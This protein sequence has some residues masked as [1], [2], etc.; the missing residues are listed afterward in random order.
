MLNL[1]SGD[2]S[3]EQ[4]VCRDLFEGAPPNDPSIPLV[5]L[6]HDQP[7]SFAYLPVGSEKVDESFH[8]A[9]RN[10]ARVQVEVEQHEIAGLSVLVASGDFYASEKI[11]DENSQRARSVQRWR[12]PRW[13][14]RD[15]A[16]S[17]TPKDSRFR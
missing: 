2:T 7:N 3:R 8:E 4:G 13:E 9:L 5:F 10:L 12:A 14:G 6:G 16:V 1:K 11:L 17:R 15:A